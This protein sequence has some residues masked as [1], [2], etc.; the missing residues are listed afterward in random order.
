MACEKASR[1]L[2]FGDVKGSG[3]TADPRFA[4]LLLKVCKPQALSCSE[5]DTKSLKL[6]L[7]P[8]GAV[9]NKAT[10]VHRKTVAFWLQ[11]CNIECH[12]R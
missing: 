5:Q 4:F 1:K 12:R 7:N 3:W 11:V 2:T 9:L 10:Y 6:V 8:T